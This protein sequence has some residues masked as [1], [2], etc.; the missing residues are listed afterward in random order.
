MWVKTSIRIWECHTCG[1]ERSCAI[2]RNEFKR[3]F[4]VV[5]YICDPQTYKKI[6]E[7]Q[8]ERWLHGA[9]L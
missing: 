8:K 9:E 6:S 3:Q 5:C 2:V 4:Q 7:E 1:D